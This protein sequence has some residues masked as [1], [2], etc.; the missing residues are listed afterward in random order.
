MAHL[1]S[2]SPGTQ[3]L[4]HL[5][6]KAAQLVEL[7]TE[8]GAIYVQ[9]SAW[10]RV[11]LQWIFRNFHVLSTQ[12]LSRSDQRLI[13]QL[14][15]FAVVRPPL[16]VSGTAVLG[17]IE[18]AHNRSVAVDEPAYPSFGESKP[19]NLSLG[20]L[21]T[22]TAICVTVIL[23]SALAS[24]TTPQRWMSA[25]AA[26]SPGTA[27]PRPVIPAHP[28]TLHPASPL[29]DLSSR[30]K[31]SG[32]EGPAVPPPVLTTLHPPPPL[33][34]RSSRPLRSGVEDPAVH[35][36]LLTTLPSA[37]PAPKRLNG[38]V[39]LKLLIGADGAVKAVTVIRG[40]PQLA[41]AGVRAARR[42]HCRPTEQLGQPV[43]VETL[44]TMK[45]FGPDAVSIASVTNPVLR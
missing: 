26:L 21:S 7:R 2:H 41:E 12:V 10:Q 20:Q 40:D 32:V 22:L 43:E 30:P 9:P 6:E 17:V 27:T 18:K 25:S 14:A 5:E 8:T 35:P 15:Q 13:A 19:W 4:K 29:L 3:P 16:P 36:S 31:Q 37:S 23:G 24:S 1:G 42:W 28:T 11:R 39:Q 45:F 44:V 38:E 33:S 34:D